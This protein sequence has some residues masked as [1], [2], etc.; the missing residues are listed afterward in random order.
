M[1]SACNGAD[2]AAGIESREFIYG[3]MPVIFYAIE[4]LDG[5]HKIRN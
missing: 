4:L 3:M 1:K 5:A 2:M